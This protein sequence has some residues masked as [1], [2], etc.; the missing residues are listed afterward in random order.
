VVLGV[1]SNLFE[2]RRGRISWLEFGDL[3]V[4]LY[5]F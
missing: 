2:H 5:C 3:Q 4:V 1:D